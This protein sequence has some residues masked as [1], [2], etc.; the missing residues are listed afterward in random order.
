MRKTW[1]I[2]KKQGRK[3]MGSQSGGFIISFSD[4]ADFYYIKRQIQRLPNIR[5]I[6]CTITT[7][8]LYIRT[9]TQ[10]MERGDRIND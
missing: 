6:Y 2:K 1:N 8:K 9:Q 5:L 10:L 3:R 4:D 7:D